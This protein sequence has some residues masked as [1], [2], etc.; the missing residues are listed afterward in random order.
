MPAKRYG[1]DERFASVLPGKRHRGVLLIGGALLA[2]GSPALAQAAAV[3]QFEQ[4]EL[5]RGRWQADLSDQWQG[6]DREFELSYGVSEQLALGLE[7]ESGGRGI[8]GLGASALVQF[9]DREQGPLG[10]GVKLSAAVD[11]GGKLSE[12]EIRAIFENLSA[13]WWGQ[14]NVMLRHRREDGERGEALAYGLSLSRRVA[15]SWW[16]GLDA[17]G[18]AARLGGDSDELGPSHLAGPSVTIELE[19]V[20]GAEAELGLAWLNRIDERGE[21]LR[22]SLQ[23]TF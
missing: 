2:A 7:M 6:G 20:E 19:P 3:E 15:R 1:P 13:R 10:A 9:S 4:L 14:A 17:S 5:D 22:A 23:L 21:T 18:I 12:V 8:D 16:L 11:G